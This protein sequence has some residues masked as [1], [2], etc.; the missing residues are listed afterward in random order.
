MVCIVDMKTQLLLL[1]VVVIWQFI[2]R[3]RFVHISTFLS[4]NDLRPRRIGSQAAELP[5]SFAAICH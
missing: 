5:L 1:P 3:G 2:V 4:D